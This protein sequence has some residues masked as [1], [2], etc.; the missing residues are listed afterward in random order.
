MVDDSLIEGSEAVN[1]ALASVSSGLATIGSPAMAINTISDNDIAAAEL[2]IGDVTVTEGNVLSFPVTR[3][4]N[5]AIAASANYTTVDFTAQAGSD[6]TASSGTVSFSAGQTSAIV[7]VVTI[8][9]STIESTEYMRVTLSSPS[10]NTTITNPSAIGAINDNEPSFIIIASQ[11]LV[12]PTEHQATYTCGII[13][14]LGYGV[15]FLNSNGV[16]VYDESQPN[17]FDPF[18]SNAS[19]GEIQVEAQAYGTGVAP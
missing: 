4:G 11:M 9:D 6:Y 14:E 17:P 1:V 2:A 15:C 16:L 10:S 13:F 19:F 5:S 7:N 12:V 18:Y 8:D 3:S